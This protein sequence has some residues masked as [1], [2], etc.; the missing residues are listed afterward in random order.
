MVKNAGAAYGVYWYLADKNDFSLRALEKTA[1]KNMMNHVAA[2]NTAN[3]DKKTV[4]G[5][6]V[7]NEGH[8]T[9][10]QK[11]TG[12]GTVYQNPAT[13]SALSRFTSSTSFQVR[14]MWEHQVN[15]ANAVKESNYPV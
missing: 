4:I 14:T 3:G 10:I 8:V 1:V 7:N 13:W 11:G 2:Y 15:L 6:D 12:G 9:A 5:V